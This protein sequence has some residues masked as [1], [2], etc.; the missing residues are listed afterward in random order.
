MIQQ[1]LLKFITNAN[2][3]LFAIFII[4]SFLL[5]SLD[6]TKGVIAGGFIVTINFHL[7]YKTLKKSLTPSKLATHG[8]VLVKYYIRFIVSGIL[9]FF[10]IN[11]KIVDPIGLIIGLSVVVASIMLATVYELTKIIFRE[12]V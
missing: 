2:W 5:F 9:I 1:K 4:S 6:F 11:F 7:L 10:L 8:S 12:A 3:I